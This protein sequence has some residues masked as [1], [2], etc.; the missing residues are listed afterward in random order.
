[1]LYVDA[2]LTAYI[3]FSPFN[4]S[5]VVVLVTYETV[6]ETECLHRLSS[7]VFSI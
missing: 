6:K 5:T 2:Y 4:S 7:S 3:Y 1:L